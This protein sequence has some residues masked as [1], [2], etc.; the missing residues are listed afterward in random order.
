MNADVL[1]LDSDALAAV[2]ACYAFGRIP[3]ADRG[4]RRGDAVTTTLLR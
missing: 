4:Q 2:V 3:F 1:D